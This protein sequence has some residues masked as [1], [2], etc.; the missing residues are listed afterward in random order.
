MVTLNRIY[1][2]GGDKGL[3]SLGDGSR[4]NKD[5]KRVQAIGDVDELNTIL[6]LARLHVTSDLKHLMTRL[7]HDLF[8]I[9]A[10]LCM[11][12]D[13][14]SKPT[15]R[16]QESHIIGLEKEI[17]H[18]NSLLNPLTSFVLPGGSQASVALHMARAITRRA[19][20]VVFSLT[21]DHLVNDQ[22]AIYLNRLSDLLFVL[23]R[24]ENN[25]GKEDIL[26]QPGLSLKK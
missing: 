4:V 17:D 10:D 9:G 23:A 22:V 6:G 13:H 12:H 19:E 21:Q 1:T 24:V 8:D 3:T 20:R 7:Q 25:H 15:L 2:R 11:P 14:R 16:I 18:Y 5:D 26:W